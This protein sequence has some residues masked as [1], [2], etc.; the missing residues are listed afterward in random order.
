MRDQ[1]SEIRVK[2]LDAFA[3][4]ETSERLESLRQHYL[5]KKGVLTEILKG[6]GKLSHDERRELGQL[7]NEIKQL[8]SSGDRRTA[9]RSFSIKRRF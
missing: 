2:G 3:T 4:A 9:K 7:A 8:I 1:L 5:G 6:L